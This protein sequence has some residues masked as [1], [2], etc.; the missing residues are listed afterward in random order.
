MSNRNLQHI[1]N[2]INIA[3]PLPE[4]GVPM[5]FSG[6]QV[7]TPGARVSAVDKA[8]VLIEPLRVVDIAIDA[9]DAVMEIY[10][11]DFSVQHKEDS[12]PLTEADLAA[13]RIIKSKLKLLTPSIPILSEESL[14]DWEIR[15]HWQY[16]WVVDPVD[17]TKEFVNRTDEFTINIALVENN[18]PILGVVHAP[19]L[20]VTYYAVRGQGAFKLKVGEQPVS[21]KANPVPEEGTLKIVGSRSHQSEAMTEYMNQLMATRSDIEFVKSGSAL[22]FCLVADGTADIYPRLAPTSEWDS[23]AGH[24]VVNE[25]GKRV[26]QY[27]KTE[28]LVYN[29]QDLLNPWFI[30]S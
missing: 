28:E 24:I 29:K 6:P 9:G 4:Q 21:I 5:T 30:V 19:A 11:T 25:S 13:N 26:V 2:W 8:N 15:K 18:K 23:A 20:G 12:S 22:K 1:M 17:G 27:G 7:H 14:V 3:Q 16:L 10:R